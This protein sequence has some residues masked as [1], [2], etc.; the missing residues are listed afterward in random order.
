VWRDARD[1]VADMLLACE[2]VADFTA[3]V[4]VSSL[5]RDTLR[6]RAVERSLSILGEAAKRVP[7]DVRQRHPAIPWRAVTGLRDVLVHDYFGIDLAVLEEV[8][9]QEIPALIDALRRLN[10]DE[11]WSATAASDADE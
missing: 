3:D 7:S 2:E 9:R 11:G 8:I 10:A 5:G 4:D 1:A 6:L